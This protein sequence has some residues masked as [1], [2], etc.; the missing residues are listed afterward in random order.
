MEKYKSQGFF[1]LNVD[2]VTSAFQSERIDFDGL[3]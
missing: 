3:F 1:L 2:L